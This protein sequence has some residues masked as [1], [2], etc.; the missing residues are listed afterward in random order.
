M[1][2]S[3]QTRPRRILARDRLRAAYAPRGVAGLS[4]KFRQLRLV[5]EQGMSVSAVSSQ[6]AA[7]VD[8]SVRLPRIT[9]ARPPHGR[10]HPAE[11]SDIV[12]LLRFFGPEVY[13]GLRSIELVPPPVGSNQLRLGSLLVPGRIKLFALLPSPW[14]LRGTLTETE[15]QRLSRAGANLQILGDGLQTIVQWPSE[16]LRDFVL[17][18]VLMHEIG[19]HVVQQ[20]TGKR[21]ERVRRT[22]DHEAFAD[23]FARRARLEYA[24][25]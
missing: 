15:M 24:N 9:I 6:D 12:D 5:K 19:H 23:H 8:F 21:S 4:R 16:T 2:R 18:D 11:R 3:V 1:A 7:R 10:Y 22:R 25:S 20:Y 17:F 13:Y 14:M